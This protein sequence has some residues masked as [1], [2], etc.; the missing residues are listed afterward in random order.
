MKEVHLD[1]MKT[2]VKPWTIQIAA[3]RSWL[4][5]QVHTWCDEN[6]DMFW[7]KEF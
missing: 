2:V 7:S 1:M 3:G 6:L 5:Q 4:Y